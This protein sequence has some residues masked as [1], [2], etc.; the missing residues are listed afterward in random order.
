MVALF[1]LNHYFSQK[2]GK[3]QIVEIMDSVIQMHRDSRNTMLSRAGNKEKVRKG[4]VIFFNRIKF[5][6]KTS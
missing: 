5:A 3:I 6:S 1:H 2:I 4:W